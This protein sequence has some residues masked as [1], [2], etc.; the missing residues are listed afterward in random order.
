MSARHDTAPHDPVRYRLAQHNT[1][2]RA[3]AAAFT[4][5]E[6]MIALVIGGLT[7]IVALEMYARGRDLYG[8]SEHV[9]RLQEQ[10][11]TAFAVIEPD[12]EMAG[13]YGFTQVAQSVRLIRGGNADAAIAPSQRLR[14]FPT[15]AG[16]ALPAAVGGLPAGAHT[17]GVN[18]AVDVSTPVQGSNNAFV[19]GRSPAGSCNP[20][21]GRAQPDADTLTLRRVETQT[22]DAEA[23]RLQ[24][25]AS[26]ST[27]R[28]AQSLFADGNAPGPIDESHRVHNFVVRTYYIARDSVGQRDF[29]ALRVKSLT[30]SGTSL[31]FDE[32]EVMAG[33]EDLQVQFGIGS[34]GTG[35]ATHYVDPDSP[36]LSAAQVVAVRIWLRVRADRPE[37][38]FVDS[39]IYRYANVTYTPAGADR[40]FRRVLMSRTV[41]LRNARSL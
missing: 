9:A 4:L 21:Q 1:S 38:T 24:I 30:R 5:V 6:L 41:T 13:F 28:S 39:R 35:R 15:R 8:V 23:N 18:F 22:S 36:E 12:V 20:Y 34:E 31:I 32:D 25:Y 3:C 19:L 26:L 27:S 29:P 7:V 37:P 40:S 17:C 2:P 11:R 10:A 16:D 33:I 14:Q